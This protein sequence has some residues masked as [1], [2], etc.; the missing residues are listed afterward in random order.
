MAPL[1]HRAAIRKIEDRNH[2]MKI[3]MVSL[4]HRATIKKSYSDDVIIRPHRLYYVCRCS[5]LLSTE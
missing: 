4:L 2:R 3:Y 1:L 5:L